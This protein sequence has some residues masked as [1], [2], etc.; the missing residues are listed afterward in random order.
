MI[1]IAITGFILIVEMA[2]GLWTGSLALPSDAAHVF[3]D[4]AFFDI[5]RNPMGGVPSFPDSSTQ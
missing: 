1:S 2:G 5:S 3:L 4:N